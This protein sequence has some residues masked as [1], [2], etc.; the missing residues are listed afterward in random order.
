[1]KVLW[2][3]NT[4]SLYVA[5]EHS[6]YGGGWIESLEREIRSEKE[7]ELGIAFLSK[8]DSGEKNVENVKYFP[9][10]SRQNSV[11]KLISRYSVRIENQSTNK[12]IIQLI[13]E[14]KPDLIHVFGTE[15]VFA[16]L[17]VDL[18]VPVVIHLQ[19]LITPYLNSFFP[20]SISAYSLVFNKYLLVDNLLGRGIYFHYLQMRKKAIREQYFLS[21][22][23]YIVGRTDWDKMISNLYASNAN[24]FF[25]NEVLRPAFYKHHNLNTP[26]DR[27]VIVT[28]I[29]NTI[30]KGLDIIL[31]TAD[32]IKKNLD[33][34]FVWKVIGISEEEKMVKFFEKHLGINSSKVNVEYCGVLNEDSL[35][36]NLK[37]CSLFIHPSYIDNSPNSICEAQIMGLPVIACNAG[38][39]SSLIEDKETGYLVPT[40]SPHNIVS[41][42]KEYSI[43]SSKFNL[44]GKKAKIIAEK[45]HNKNDIKTATI[46]LYRKL[47]DDNNR[48]SY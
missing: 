36:E 39:V 31:K 8:N 47:L 29:S 3:T 22:S 32:L 44:V 15:G 38:G 33:V 28:T 24:Y 43:S 40:N 23:K 17:V 10:N 11:M 20:S 46:N 2:F 35:V 41:L 26:L 9:L 48:N 21:R 14:F 34:K 19:G 5:E 6:Y 27:V 13:N 42:V 4:P 45:R 7:I 16:S 30:Y 18:K 12:N 37:N 25:I 1:M